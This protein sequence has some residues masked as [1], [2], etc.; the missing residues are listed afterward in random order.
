MLVSNA[1]KP[2]DI[3]DED[4]IISTYPLDIKPEKVKII[5]VE[6]VFLR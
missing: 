1:R 5:P 4:K 2:Q 3:L 6:E